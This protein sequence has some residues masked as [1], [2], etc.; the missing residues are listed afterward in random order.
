MEGTST[1]Q[2]NHASRQ[3]DRQGRPSNLILLG[4]FETQQDA[5]E[6]NFIVIVQGCWRFAD[7]SLPI[8]EGEVCAILIFQHILA[9]LNKDASVQA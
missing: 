5:T 6:F 4:C 1:S 7:Q 9:V 3:A 2:T 8:E